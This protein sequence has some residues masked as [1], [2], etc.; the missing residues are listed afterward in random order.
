[1]LSSVRN[2]KF[3]KMSKLNMF[4]NA[5]CVLFY[6]LNMEDFT[7]NIRRLADWLISQ[8]LEKLAEV[9]KGVFSQC[10]GC[11]SLLRPCQGKLQQA[12]WP[13]K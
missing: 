9:F 3:I 8:G 2:V 10:Y 4:I 5:V 12:T 13:K 7:G 6:F 11:I 1:M